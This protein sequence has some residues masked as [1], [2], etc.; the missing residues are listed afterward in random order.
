MTAWGTEKGEKAEKKREREGVRDEKEG[1]EKSGVEV[2][3]TSVERTIHYLKFNVMDR[4]L[5]LQL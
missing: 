3:Y 1:E 2:L 5:Y 4:K